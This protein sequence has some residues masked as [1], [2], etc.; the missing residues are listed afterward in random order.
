M[1]KTYEQGNLALFFF[2][3]W[4]FFRF[5]VFVNFAQ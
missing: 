3:E 4:I 2:R 1:Q 5:I